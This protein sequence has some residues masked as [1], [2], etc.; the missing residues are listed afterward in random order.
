M[1]PVALA[2]LLLSLSGPELLAATHQQDAITSRITRT[3]VDSSAIASVGYSNRLHAL[4]IEF[5]KG[6]IYRYLH[7]PKKIYRELMA[8]H[9]KARY[10]D[11]NI[12]HRFRSVHVKPRPYIS[13]FGPTTQPQ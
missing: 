10:Y 2:L 6:P 4:E 12:R 7:V 13:S 1:W 9:S 8:A 11:H 3:H 5:R